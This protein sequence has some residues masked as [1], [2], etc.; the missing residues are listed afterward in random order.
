[1]PNT[2]RCI[3]VD[4]CITTAS[5]K[6][7]SG[8]L[9]GVVV[10]PLNASENAAINTEAK[11]IARCNNCF[12]FINPLCAAQSNW[13]RC[14]L[15][16]TK[17]WISSAPKRFQTSSRM[18]LPEMKQS[19]I[20]YDLPLYSLGVDDESTI[21]QQRERERIV[22]LAIVDET[23]SK[24]FMN[25][26]NTSILAALEALGDDSWFGRSMQSSLKLLFFNNCRPNHILG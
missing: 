1:M 24:E 4:L 26:L 11:N 5:I 17:N 13:W 22:H 6:E 16:E 8:L 25:L 9:W 15:C 10:Q 12:A 20:E 18:L 7:E 3:P 2:C 14:S 19:L 23:G 21:F